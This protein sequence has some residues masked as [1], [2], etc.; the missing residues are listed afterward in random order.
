MFPDLVQRNFTAAEPNQVYVG[1]ICLT[2]ATTQ[3][4]RNLWTTPI[5]TDHCV[6]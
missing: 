6:E 4:A 1:D 2:S 5:D 3:D